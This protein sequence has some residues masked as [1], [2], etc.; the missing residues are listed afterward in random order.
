MSEHTAD[1]RLRVDAVDLS[2]S[3]GE[4]FVRNQTAPRF[5]GRLRGDRCR[6][7]SSLVIGRISPHHLDIPLRGLAIG[8]INDRYR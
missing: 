5:Q 1:D 8:G 7:D 3:S 6:R 2:L 4:L